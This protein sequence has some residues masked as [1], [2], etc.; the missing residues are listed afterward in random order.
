MKG[1]AEDPIP[2]LLIIDHDPGFRKKGDEALTEPEFLRDLLAV[3]RTTG[4]PQV[5]LRSIGFELPDVRNHLRNGNSFGSDRPDQG[6]IDIDVNDRAHALAWPLT[7]TVET[8]HNRPP[9]P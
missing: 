5:E 7:R 9:V 1:R 2:H 8:P 6:V 3:I 4:T